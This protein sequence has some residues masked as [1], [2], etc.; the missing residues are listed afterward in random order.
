MIKSA[1]KDTIENRKMVEGVSDI[2]QNN[3]HELVYDS[4]FARK[5]R[6]KANDPVVCYTHHL[7]FPNRRHFR[8]HIKTEHSIE[9]V[10]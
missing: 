3:V 9:Q 10:G 6:V 8:H 7:E 2:N 1:L 4:A 5:R